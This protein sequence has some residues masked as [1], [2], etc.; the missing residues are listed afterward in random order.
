MKRIVLVD[1]CRIPEEMLINI[2]HQVITSFNSASIFRE[3]LE[4]MLK[5]EMKPYVLFEGKDDYHDDDG[6]INYEIYNNYIEQFIAK[7]KDIKKEF[8]LLEVYTEG[9]EYMLDIYLF[10]SKAEIFDALAEGNS[11]NFIL[12]ES[13]NGDIYFFDNKIDFFAFIDKM[14]EL[15]R[16]NKISCKDLRKVKEK[17]KKEKS[18]DSMGIFFVEKTDNNDELYFVFNNEDNAK[19][20]LNSQETQENI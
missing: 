5:K 4:K 12:S 20:A 2:T 6:E 1:G 16:M 19:E 13:N 15:N 9:K 3:Y 10:T 8:Y 18:F 17:V 7:I 14:I 11:M